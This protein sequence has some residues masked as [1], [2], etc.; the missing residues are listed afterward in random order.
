MANGAEPPAPSA[1]SH[2]GNQ[3]A[4]AAGSTMASAGT[5]GNDRQGMATT[6]SDGNRPEGENFELIPGT[7]FRTT[8][9]QSFHDHARNAPRE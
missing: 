5:N 7:P 6:G 3:A 4:T 8:L 1:D 9:D 2:A